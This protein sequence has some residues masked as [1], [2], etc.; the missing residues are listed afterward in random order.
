MHTLYLHQELQEIPKKIRHKQQDI[1][2]YIGDYI[3]E[4][5]IQSHDRLSCTASLTHDASNNEIYGS[6]LVVLRSISIQ[7]KSLI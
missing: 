3:T 2:S 6:L 7:M 1:V 5:N 4:L